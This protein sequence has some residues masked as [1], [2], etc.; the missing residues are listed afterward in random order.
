MGLWKRQQTCRM[1][2]LGNL[3]DE[4]QTRFVTVTD[5]ESFG[6][7]AARQRNWLVLA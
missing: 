7:P 4:H 5:S 1:T 6:S 2:S 3:F